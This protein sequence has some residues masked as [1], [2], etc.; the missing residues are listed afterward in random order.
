MSKRSSGKRLPAVVSNIPRDLRTFLDRVRESLESTGRDKFLTRADLADL[1]ILDDDDA[2]AVPDPYADCTSPPAPS[3]VTATAAVS[4]IIL[5]WSGTKYPCH[6]HAEVWGAPEGSLGAAVLLGTTAAN[7]YVD[8]VGSGVARYYWVR[9]INEPGTAGP[10]QSVAG[11]FA[12]TPPA[13]DYLLETLAGSITE[14]QLFEDLGARI[15][16]IDADGTVPGSV[17][18]RL[19]ILNTE[20]SETI[21]DLDTDVNR[22]LADLYADVEGTFA[23]KV[24]LTTTKEDIFG[25]AVDDFSNISARFVDTDEA[26]EARATKTELTTAISD[27]Y[28]S[29]VTDFVRISA[30]F[31]KKNRT[32]VQTSRP[33]NTSD[34]TLVEGDLWINPNDSNRIRRWNG[35]RHTLSNWEYVDDARIAGH[36]A[37]IYSINDVSA[38]SDSAIA[39]TVHGLEAEIHDPDTGLTSRATIQEINDAVA[40]VGG[41]RVDSLRQLTSTVGANEASVEE[42]AKSIDGLR[43]QYTVKVDN[44][45]HVSGFGLASGPV[46]GAIVSS[47]GVRA[48]RFWIASPGSSD[49]Q[50]DTNTPFTVTTTEQTI[51]GETVPPGTYIRNA[52]I[53]NGSI[54]SAKIAFAAIDDAKIA[55]VSAGKIKAGSIEA[56]EFVRSS[57]YVAGTQGWTIT[58]SGY[59]EFNDAVV[60]GTVYATDGEFTGKVTATDGLFRG[61]VHGQTT[62]RGGDATAW[63]VGTGLYASAEGGSYQFR[64]GVPDGERLEWSENR[65]TI[66]D[67]NG[68]V[69]FTT[70]GSNTLSWDDVT[71]KPAFGDFAWLNKIAGWNVGTYIESAAI[72]EAYIQDS[73]ITNAKIRDAAITTAKIEVA[74]IDTLR[75]A[76]QTVVVPVAKLSNSTTGDS[77]SFSVNNLA[78]GEQV[79]VLIHVG[80]VS[81]SGDAT[82]SVYHRAGGSTYDRLLAQDIAWTGH[83][84]YIGAGSGTGNGTNTIRVDIRDAGS[85]PV[86]LSINAIVC[87]R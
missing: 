43:V 62:I 59:A 2:D 38:D 6:A 20:I 42:H 8:P 46:D 69:S 16:L 81:S 19:G 76:G 25:A 82:F 70:G 30:A 56:G 77:I 13:I 47:F 72:G 39:R 75:L 65:L 22:R 10:Y 74:A 54:D 7:V 4:N 29:E 41:T 9:F 84:A 87:K 79:P 45:G 12:E 44:N 27:V 85:G 24:A 34:Y 83:R 55:S 60:R 28:K 32:F 66:Y 36:E 71:D 1:G 14:E 3:G 73:A 48:D 40:G 5:E 80:V 78:S 57:S 63:G 33:T 18:E 49:E 51:G 35:V 50:G 68:D 26:L 67:D 53:Q 31:G 64:L 61:T 17:N 52:F 86:R 21:D 15:D 11:V 23:T 58:G 37:D